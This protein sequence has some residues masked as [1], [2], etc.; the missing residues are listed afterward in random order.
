MI[1]A[2]G[3]GRLPDG[4]EKDVSYLDTILEYNITGDSYTQIGIMSKARRGHAISVVR[5]QD[6]SEWFQ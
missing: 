4:K 3:Q 6:F 1:L 2:G 5:N